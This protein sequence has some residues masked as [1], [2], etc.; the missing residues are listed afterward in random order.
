MNFLLSIP[1]FLAGPYGPLIRIGLVLVLIATVWISGWVKGSQHG[2]RKLTD[3]QAEQATKAIKIMQGRTQVVTKVVTEYVKVAGKT[4]V[5]TNTIEKE[6]VRYADSNTGSCLDARWRVLHDASAR[7]QVPPSPGGTDEASGAPKAAAAI[8][9]V[10]ENYAAC[11]RTA[12]R[13]DALQNLLRGW[14]AVPQ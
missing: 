7:N 5:V 9:T 14:E 10:T 2:T 4:Q 3:Y 6:V 12:D 8:G 11:N 13:L 1:T